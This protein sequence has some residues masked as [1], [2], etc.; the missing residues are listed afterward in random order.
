MVARI[1]R[2]T[3]G[4]TRYTRK[5]HVWLCATYVHILLQVQQLHQSISHLCLPR[6]AQTLL[7]FLNTLQRRSTFGSSAPD[8]R[9]GHTIIKP[10]LAMAP[11]AAKTVSFYGAEHLGTAGE[12]LL[13]DP[14]VP[15]VE[16][17]IASELA[18]PSTMIRAA[19]Q[20]RVA[21]PLSTVERTS[22]LQP[23]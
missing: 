18:T 15:W 9:V 1:L 11:K 19:P 22:D 23:G 21:T 6:L 7:M 12:L 16:T 20:T 2:T 10:L 17:S 14:S 4:Y 13:R 5:S 3:Y 8:A